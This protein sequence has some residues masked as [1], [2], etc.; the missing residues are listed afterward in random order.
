[1][2][3]T[4][5]SGAG[6]ALSTAIEKISKFGYTMVATLEE[7]FGNWLLYTIGLFEKGRPEIV[8]RGLAPEVA[9]P[10]LAEL[11]KLA[12]SG[13]ELAPGVR[14]DLTADRVLHLVPSTTEGLNVIRSLYG[15]GAPVMQVVWPDDTGAYPW[16]DMYAMAHR[17]P[18]L[19][20]P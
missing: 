4:A 18:R 8:M 5:D 7:P 14:A 11:A 19:P 1:M 17:Q 15:G 13:D 12:M 3:D 6:A 20:R 9:Q 10:I 2:S 16:D